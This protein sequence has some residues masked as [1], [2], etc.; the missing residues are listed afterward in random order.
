MF[1]Q[2]RHDALKG[3]NEEGL[4]RSKY[5]DRRGQEPRIRSPAEKPCGYEH[6]Q[7]EAAAKIGPHH[8]SPAIP[9]VGE[10]SADERCDENNRGLGRGE[11][12]SPWTQ[13][14][15]SD[16]RQYDKVELIAQRGKREC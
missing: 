15:D 2:S 7:D 13:G 9:A 8:S 11:I 5:N 14:I 3:R 4:C 12:A 6:E 16:P 1:D 10:G